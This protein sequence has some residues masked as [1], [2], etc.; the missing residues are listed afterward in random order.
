MAR[1][2]GQPMNSQSAYFGNFKLNPL[3]LAP[4]LLLSLVHKALKNYADEVAR[5]NFFPFVRNQKNFPASR[6]KGPVCTRLAHVSRLNNSNDRCMTMQ[7][8]G[9]VAAAAKTVNFAFPQIL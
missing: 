2:L 8:A 6:L 9:A 4:F 1:Q 7:A 3:N 5:S